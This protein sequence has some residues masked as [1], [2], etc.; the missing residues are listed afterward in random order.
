M[1]RKQ[2]PLVRTTTVEDLLP[3]DDC[4]IEY[5]LENGDFH[6]DMTAVR[7]TDRELL[8]L[9]WECRDDRVYEVIRQ[10]L[11]DRGMYRDE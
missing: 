9:F 5:V 4:S 3:L 1:A 2:K 11:E 10:V 6:R 8:E 7:V